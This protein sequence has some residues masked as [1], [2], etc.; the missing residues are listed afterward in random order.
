MSTP[1]LQQQ[2]GQKTEISLSYDAFGRLVLERPG[3]ERLVGVAPVRCFPFSAPGGP[4]SFCDENGRE[5]YCLAALEDLPADTR[6]ALEN[7][8]ARRELMPLIR[9]ILDVTP[10]PEPTTWRVETDR[11]ERQFVLSSD[12]D[13]RR[14]GTDGA[15]I[16]DE[17]GLRFL[18][19]D[20]RSLD[21]Q[22]RKILER[23][24]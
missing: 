8:L 5:V 15:L 6:K 18:I 14:V 10:P 16:A 2:P 1:A 4:V 22:S 3:A 21:S 23:Y 7:D 9:K 13:V 12:D 11:G 20:M 24:L 17:H 19:R